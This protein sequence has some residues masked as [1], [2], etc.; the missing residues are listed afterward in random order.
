MAILHKTDTYHCRGRNLVELDFSVQGIRVGAFDGLDFFGDGSFYLLN[1][2]GH[3]IGHLGGLART[4]SN[5]ETFIF[6]GG[7]LCHHGGEIRPSLYMSI[8]PN[9]TEPLSDLIRARGAC[10]GSAL[11]E[12]LNIKRGRKANEPFFDPAMGVD[13]P[14]AIQTIKDTQIAD[15]QQDVFFIYAHDA[16]IRGVVDFFPLPANDWR[17]KGWREKT[18]WAF[19]T[20]LVG[21]IGRQ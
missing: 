6:M 10:P 21:A 20:D 17:K 8:P 3:A 11:F 12:E 1:T 2:P 9:L 16:T 18:L 15:A 5:P 7:D 19:L 14:L 13:I 4:S